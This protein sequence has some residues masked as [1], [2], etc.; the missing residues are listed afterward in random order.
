MAKTTQKIWKKAQKWEKDWH[1]N[2]VNSLNEEQKQLVYA[3]KMGL[4]RTPTNKTPYTFDLKGISVIDVGAGPYS[5]LLKCVNFK[6]AIAIDPLM[7][8]FP[9][10]IL[11][12]YDALKI[13][14]V[15]ASGEKLDGVT[16]VDEIWIY[17]VLQHVTDPKKVIDGMKKIAK[18]IRLF[19][20]I[21]TGTNIGHL[22]N[23]TKKRLDRWLGGEGKSEQL[24]QS[25]CIGRAYFGVFKGDDYEEI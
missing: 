25:G 13:I 17:N 19:E 18:T 7:D 10:W 22:H 11:K 14:P 23:L 12:R 8:K 1:G 15:K 6:K 5:L 21:N 24:N 4:V 16:K 20:W 2:C 9:Q 3:E